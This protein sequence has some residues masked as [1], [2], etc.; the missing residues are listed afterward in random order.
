M[1]KVLD[2]SLRIADAGG[3]R[4]SGHAGLCELRA[5]SAAWLKS[6]GIVRST[7]GRARDRRRAV[8]GSGAKLAGPRLPAGALCQAVFTAH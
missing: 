5:N 3:M 8:P 2:G 6:G 1:D 7:A 4:T